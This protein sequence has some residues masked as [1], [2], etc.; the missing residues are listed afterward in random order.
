MKV[1]GEERAGNEGRDEGSFVPGCLL[2][3][4][5]FSCPLFPTLSCFLL[6]PTASLPPPSHVQD[7]F[8]EKADALVGVARDGEL[9]C[10]RTFTFDLNRF[11]LP[12]TE[13]GA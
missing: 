3:F 5:A 1:W 2:L 4:R 13:A 10:S 9:G 6:S 11:E 12:E 8:Y 7:I